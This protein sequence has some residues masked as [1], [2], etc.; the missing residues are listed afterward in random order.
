VTVRTRMV[1]LFLLAALCLA[2]TARPPRG[3]GGGTDGDG[4]AAAWWYCGGRAPPCDGDR[5]PRD[6]WSAVVLRVVDGDTVDLLAGG[7]SVRVRLIGVDAPETWPRRDCLGAEAA[8]RLRGLLPRGSPV[9]AAG[10]RE[11]VD[12]YGRRLL[13][14]WA[15]GGRARPG[16]ATTRV[17]PGTATTRVPP[18]TATTRVPPGT[19]TTRAPPGTA[20]TRSPAFVAGSLIRAGLARAMY[21]PPNIRYATALH[22]AESAA[23]RSGAGLWA[24]CAPA[25]TSGR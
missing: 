13:Y 20:T 7:R 12:R 1:M 9:R 22:A 18:G 6:A 16:T 8:R 17:R 10:D 4:R 23:R 19:A 2:L 3:L 11:A 24:A 15:R 21:V 25:T 14:L 5:P